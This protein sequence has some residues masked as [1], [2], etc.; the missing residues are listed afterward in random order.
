MAQF[1]NNQSINQPIKEIAMEDLR[2]T[3]ISIIIMAIESRKSF[4]SGME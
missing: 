4:S 3:F 2:F 1:L